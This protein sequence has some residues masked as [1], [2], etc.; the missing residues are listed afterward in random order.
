[1]DTR[2]VV[3]TWKDWIVVEVTVVTTPCMELFDCAKANSHHVNLHSLQT[4]RTIP[5]YSFVQ[6]L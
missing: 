6:T 1:M 5:E 4:N 2:D 3:G